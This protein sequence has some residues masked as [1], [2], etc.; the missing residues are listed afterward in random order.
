MFRQK[1]QH[2]EML[3]PKF[4]A[5]LMKRSKFTCVWHLHQYLEVQKG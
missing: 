4:W 5:K 2:R 1:K 3:L